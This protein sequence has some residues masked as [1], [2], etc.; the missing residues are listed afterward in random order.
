MYI[1][2]SDVSHA[3]AF[4]WLEENPQKIFI[5]LLLTTNQFDIA[6]EKRHKCLLTEFRLRTGII[7]APAW[8]APYFFCLAYVVV[9]HAQLDPIRP[10]LQVYPENS[11]KVFKFP[12]PVL[13][14]FIIL[15]ASDRGTG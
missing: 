7:N 15:L 6:S 14:T 13:T 10:L 12:R 1:L 11:H 5:S 4:H 8:Q 3:A 9:L 2:S